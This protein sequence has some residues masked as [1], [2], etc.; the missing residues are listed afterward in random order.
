MAYT[1]GFHGHCGIHRD[2][3][4]KLYSGS[5]AWKLCKFCGIKVI[6][7]SCHCD[8]KSDFVRGR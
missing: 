2:V 5:P 4:F 8:I 7:K 6:I 1:S 3:R